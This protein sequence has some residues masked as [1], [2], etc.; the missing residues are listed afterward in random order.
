MRIAIDMQGAQTDSRFRGIGR[1]TLSLALAMVRNRGEHDI[2]LVLNGVFAD[3]IE[4][5]R[6]AFEGVLPQ[7]NIRLWYGP[8][9]VRASGSRTLNQRASELAATTVTNSPLA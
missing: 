3:T 2:V 9:A 1:Y 6:A 8:N 4:P 7:S 5:I